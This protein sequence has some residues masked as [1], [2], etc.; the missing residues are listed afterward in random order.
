M[1]A[2]KSDIAE[3]SKF[4]QYVKRAMAAL[5]LAPHQRLHF[6]VTAGAMG[7]L[8]LL[9]ILTI[10]GFASAS[11]WEAEHDKLAQMDWRQIA[12]ENERRL[13]A[14]RTREAKLEHDVQTQKRRAEKFEGKL[15]GSQ[16]KLAGSQRTIRETQARHAGD[17]KSLKKQHDD[18]RKQ[19]TAKIARLTKQAKDA[20][21][22]LAAA[23]RNAKLLQRKLEAHQEELQAVKSQRED[24]GSKLLSGVKTREQ[25]GEMLGTARSEVQRLGR[26][27]DAQ[28]KRQ[29]TLEQENA[30][31][32]A[33]A[34]ALPGGPKAEDRIL[35][36]AEAKT[37]YTALAA[38]VKAR[39][40]KHRENLATVEAVMK[41]LE[42]TR[43]HKAAAKVLVR[44]KDALAKEAN[45]AA[46]VRY[47]EAVVEVR[48]HRDDHAAN[49][50]IYSQALAKVAGTSYAARLQKL[51]DAERQAKIEVDKEAAARVLFKAAAEQ[52]DKSPH[53]HAANLAKLHQIA[54]QVKGTRYA[55]SVAKMIAAQ[56]R[57]QKEAAPQQ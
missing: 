39:P 38:D 11:G 4:E 25:T 22:T 45:A 15:A 37:I 55:K 7:L 43:Y 34:T 3:E 6:Y 44:E 8:L 32:R 51:A 14:A 24:L 31:L 57:A 21:K 28:R 36:E 49:I 42:G 56:K 40:D 54:P 53:D 23:Q 27:I 46:K 13:A 20:R 16:A 2:K 12:Q 35:S 30:R 47:K 5:K 33:L 9:L 1:N 10:T 48:K 17:L 41:R 52:I 50:S 18:A 29:E 19:S 26:E